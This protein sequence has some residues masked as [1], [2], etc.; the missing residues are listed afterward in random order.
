[1]NN[2]HKPVISIHNADD[3][4]VSDVT[5]RNIVVENA[6]IGS[7]D[8]EEMPYL[9]D[10][11]ITQSGN[12]SSTRDRG[13]IRNVTIEN[14]QVLS[15]KFNPSRIKGFDAEHTIEDVVIRNLEILGEKITDFEAGKF[16]ID[17]QTTKNISIE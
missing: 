3:A 6:Q 2:F 15:G 13:Q 12:W 1:M 4:L 17:E 14:V 5:F 9:I 8:G 10:L 16:E 7:G 11:W